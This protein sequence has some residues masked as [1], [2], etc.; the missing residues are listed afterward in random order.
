MRVGDFSGLWPIERVQS[1]KIDETSH[2]K[3]EVTMR[4]SSI[5]IK[6]RD[7]TEFLHTSNDMLHKNTGFVDNVII[8][9]L[10]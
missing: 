6:L 4:Y 9:F 2:S 8:E 7:H 3:K 10:K 1:S 5:A